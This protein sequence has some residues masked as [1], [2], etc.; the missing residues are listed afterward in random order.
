MSINLIFVFKNK[1]FIFIGGA[2]GGKGL[3]SI[4]PTGIAAIAAWK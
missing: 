3:D 1:Y 4:F 2:F